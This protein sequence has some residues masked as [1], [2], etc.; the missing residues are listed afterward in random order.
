METHLDLIRDNSTWPEL[1]ANLISSEG[2]E[3][4]ETDRLYKPLGL[5]VDQVLNRRHVA[6]VRVILPVKLRTPPPPS[7]LVRKRGMVQARK[8]FVPAGDRQSSPSCEGA[9]LG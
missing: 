2:V 1:G 7:R 3:V 6:S 5:E 9:A 4:A 8:G